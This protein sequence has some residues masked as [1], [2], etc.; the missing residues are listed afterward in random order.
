[1]EIRDNSMMAVGWTLLGLALLI[2]A[3]ILT[4]TLVVACTE[5]LLMRI[6]RLKA[7]LRSRL[8]RQEGE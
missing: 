7:R 6:N 2:L 3:F 4:G 5:Y 8:D 1:M